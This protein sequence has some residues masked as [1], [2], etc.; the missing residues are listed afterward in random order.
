MWT[1]G[2]LYTRILI[3]LAALTV[4]LQGLPAA[5]CSCCSGH[6]LSDSDCCSSEGLATSCC[7]DSHDEAS[8]ACHC[9]SDCHCGETHSSKI[10]LTPAPIQKT[11][12]EQLVEGEGVTLSL[13]LITQVRARNSVNCISVSE[14]AT[15]RCAVLCC[16]TL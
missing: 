13:T 1:T 3:C 8:S 9:G 12:S 5:T 4:P 10:P 2:S 16:F 14:R 7:T 15:D 6:N 11:P